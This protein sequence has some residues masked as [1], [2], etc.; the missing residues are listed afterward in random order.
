M[1]KQKI[2]SY[3]KARNAGYSFKK[4]LIGFLTD[5][6][7]N[8]EPFEPENIKFDFF[9]KMKDVDN[10]IKS[11]VRNNKT[12]VIMGDYDTDGITASAI[13]YK[14]LK[15]VYPDV[16][17][18]TILPD[19]HSDGYGLK[20]KHVDNAYNQNASVIITV[21]NGINAIKSCKYAMSKGMEVILT[22]H[23]IPNN[24]EWQDLEFVMNPHTSKS[25]LKEHEICGAMVALLFGLNLMKAVGY[26]ASDKFIKELKEI[27]SIGTIGDSMPIR[28]ENRA[29][30]KECMPRFLEGVAINKGLQL[31]INSLSKFTVLEQDN[32][33]FYLVPCINACGRLDSAYL[34]FELLTSESVK[35]CANL[36]T[37]LVSLNDRRK[38]ISKDIET[39][40]KTQIDAS[41]RVQILQVPEKYHDYSDREIGGIVGITASKVVEESKCP[42][43]IFYGDRFSGRS[44]PD[45]N[46]NQLLAS[47]TTPT[48]TFGGHAQACG[49]GVDFAS[50]GVS[51]KD[52]LSKNIKQF[53]NN[54]FYEKFIKVPHDV[55]PLEILK[56]F[57][58]IKPCDLN[59]I[60]SL[61][62]TDVKIESINTF[63]GHSQVTFTLN[64]KKET[65]VKFYDTLPNVKEGDTVSSIIFKISPS[66]TNDYQIIVEKVNS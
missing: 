58:Q 14:V 29:L 64:G 30:L 59:A 46:L 32:I 11:S 34:G 37:K 25:S 41:S 18:R 16:D 49:G 55:N 28:Y 31:L 2:Y 61:M 19:R 53:D 35:M 21:D 38:L 6:E 7:T 54:V 17:I 12:V 23:H 66:T 27:A 26:E 4:F 13:M 22:D 15:A 60:P 39:Y 1:I 5:R 51:L 10:I 45:I 44:M 65:A 52:E 33:A 50:Y 62:L 9:D 57:T 40:L 20:D 48:F 63:S 24:S 43:L 3:E 8:L 42:S 56:A 47:S 36:A